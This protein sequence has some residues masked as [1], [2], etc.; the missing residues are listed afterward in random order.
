MHTF[1]RAELD[2][3]MAKKALECGCSIN[4][5][6]KIRNFET[7]NDGVSVFTDKNTYFSKVIIGADGAGSIISRKLNKGKNILKIIGY[8][9]EV[10]VTDDNSYPGCGES[11]V[12]DFG[13][14]KKGYLWIFPKASVFSIGAGG[15]AGDALNIKK[16]LEW[17]LEKYPG[18]L[19]NNFSIETHKQF[20]QS[21]VQ[22][23]NEKRENRNLSH[24][25]GMATDIKDIKNKLN[26]HFI[27]VRSDKT[28]LC[29]YRVLTVGDAAGLGD[30]FTGEGLHNAFLSSIIAAESIQNA[31]SA[32][33]F[34]FIDYHDRISRDIYSNIRYSL[35][36]SKIFF[37]SPYFYYKLIKNNDNLFN[38]CAR[39]LRGEKNYSD[40]VNKLKLIKI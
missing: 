12:L 23:N 36:I 13:G 6:E 32:C 35:I 28:F 5:S 21:I 22:V 30:G 3:L 1:E 10:P 37:S 14:F 40:V 11:I 19:K 20:N 8:E 29:D 38:A 15:P 2:S 4:F 39:I 27:P 34:N 26:A 17:F 18:A 31:F 7:G 25:P 24:R 16:Y 33:N 9:M